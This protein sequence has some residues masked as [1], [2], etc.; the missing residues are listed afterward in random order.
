MMIT[1]H[2][3]KHKVDYPDRPKGTKPPA[4][5]R[6]GIDGF[7]LD[8]QSTKELEGQAPRLRLVIPTYNYARF[9]PGCLDSLLAQTFTDWVCCI[10]DDAST[11]E[12]PKVVQPYLN[13]PRLHYYRQPVNQRTGAAL[14][15]GYSLLPS[16]PYE[17]W[18]AS[19][20][21]MYPRLFERLCKTLDERPEIVFAYSDYEIAY[22]DDQD[23]LKMLRRGSDVLQGMDWNAARLRQAYFL[24]I[25]W[26]WRTA[27]RE[28]AGEWKLAPC[29][30]YAMAIKMSRQGDFVWV[31]ENLA[32]YR[33]H[34]ENLTNQLRNVGL[35]AERKVL[36]N[37]A[38]EDRLLTGKAQSTVP[39]E[40]KEQSALSRQRRHPLKV[41]NINLEFDCAGVG[42][43]L[44]E[45]F[46]LYSSSTVVK[47][48]Q[49]R[50]MPWSQMTDCT[51]DPK[52][53]QPFLDLMR[54]ADVL[55][56]NEWIWTHALGTDH[57]ANFI[58]QPKPTFDFMPYLKD[59]RVLFHFHGGLL[60]LYPDYWLDQCREVG[61]QVIVCDPLNESLI[62]GARWI[63]NLLDWQRIHPDGTR[64]YNADMGVYMAYA[65][66]AVRNGKGVD[67]IANA[68]GYLQ[69]RGLPLHWHDLHSMDWSECMIRRRPQHVCIDTLTQGFIGMTGW[70]GLALGQVVMARLQPEVDRR[71]R[72]VLGG[73]KATPIWNVSGIDELGQTLVKLHGDRKLLQER[74]AWSR[75]WV[76]KCYHPEDI[77]D[78]WETV[79]R[80]D[81]GP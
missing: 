81:D 28:A 10:V 29:E 68:I 70:E 16:T 63:P 62:E 38:A 27:A 65:G 50:Q 79:F 55:H 30:D 35:N 25:G 71:Y 46:R 69:A 20:N 52:Q 45:A 17:T 15:R 72:A 5:P 42:W 76:E 51:I 8:K 39:A 37:A 78:R 9:L 2:H 14:N 7:G 6:L 24:G 3:K 32:W 56:F 74:C 41:L 67:K 4:P 34:T 53:P 40:Q 18:F 47:H 43:M 64:V 58:P 80:G 19:D 12:T 23:R 48:A 36:D 54:W 21:I 31:P 13:D 77:V 1:I 57:V 73:G 44:R 66:P 33:A 60:Q 49:A 11:D 61:A 59:K 26:M 22:F 75:E